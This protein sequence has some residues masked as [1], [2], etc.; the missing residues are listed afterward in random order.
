MSSLAV[1]TGAA[2]GIGRA[3]ALR[4]L[5]EGIEVVAVDIDERGLD[6]VAN[7]GARLLV[8]D[9]G[10]EEGCDA[11]VAAGRGGDYLVNAAAIIRM[12]PLHEVTR[13]DWRELFRVNAESVYPLASSSGRACVKG[14]RL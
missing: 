1:V 2:S 10:T 9:L 5:R 11:V 7:S 3:T 8:A 4:L 14:V 13:E 6:V 12:Q